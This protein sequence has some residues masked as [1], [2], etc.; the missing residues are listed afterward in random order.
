MLLKHQKNYT[1]NVIRRKKNERKRTSHLRK[2]IA[3]GTYMK[4]L[5]K[6]LVQKKQAD[7]LMARTK[8]DYKDLQKAITDQKVFGYLDDYLS[9][10]TEEKIEQLITHAYYKHINLKR[11]QDE[12]IHQKVQELLILSDI[13]D[14]NKIIEDIIKQFESTKSNN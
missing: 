4:L 2:T 13:K 1:L 14:L 5:R 3:N 6:I 9:S 12:P 8:A 10:L 11:P 7:D